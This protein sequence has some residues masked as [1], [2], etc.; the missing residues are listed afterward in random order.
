MK[1]NTYEITMRHDAGQV[2]IQTRARNYDAAKHMI[3][4]AERAPESAILHWRV[5][6]TKRQIARTKSLMRGL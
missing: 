6:P 2:S 5:V 1:M 3:L 4:E